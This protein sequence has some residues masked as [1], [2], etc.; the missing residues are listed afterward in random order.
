MRVLDYVVCGVCLVGCVVG[1]C[2]VLAWLVPRWQCGVSLVGVLLP[3]VGWVGLCANGWLTLA[4]RS[5]HGW[6]I[7]GLRSLGS[8]RGRERPCFC[9]T[10]LQQYYEET[11]T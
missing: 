4:L 1:V 5:L 3:Y 6:C 10:D 9:G 2:V 7:I 8:L 11:A